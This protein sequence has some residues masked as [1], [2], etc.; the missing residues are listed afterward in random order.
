MRHW[1]LV[2]VLAGLVSAAWAEVEVI[3]GGNA[4]QPAGERSE[5]ILRTRDR[6][7][8]STQ[9]T[10]RQ[11]KTGPQTGRSETI[12]QL[13]ANDGTYFEWQRASTVSQEIAPG[14]IE[15]TTEVVELDRQGG[16]RQR[17]LVKQTTSRT[18]SGETGKTVEYWPNS[19]GNLT[20]ARESTTQITKTPAGAITETR[21]E[22]EFDVNGRAVVSRQLE[23]NTVTEGDKSTT[24]TTAKAVD[25]LHREN[26]ETLREISTTV[27]AG[28][29]TRSEVLRQ[30]RI[31]S[32]WENDGRTV[33]TESRAADGTIQ[34]ET[35]VEGRSLYSRLGGR[36]E[37]GNLSPQS[38]TVDREVRQP[39]GTIVIR[40]D[41]YRRDVNG[42]WV[43]TTFSTAG[44]QRGY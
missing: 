12:T 2:T 9:E 43:P 10:T 4:E 3:K 44:A 29:T 22:S 40:R 15:S 38:K 19:S 39:D 26:W 16:E 13:R 32:T 18:A 35:I 37:F 5:I 7:I 42:E 17:T 25:H 21:T 20:R 36:T 14:T 28:N 1:I 8:P 23:S 33:T 6:E 30:K 27:G 31:G 11:T 34:R 41:V 24:T